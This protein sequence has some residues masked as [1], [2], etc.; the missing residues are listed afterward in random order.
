MHGPE[1]FF[2]DLTALGL[3]YHRQATVNGQVF[4]IFPDYQV[5][6]GRFAGR[7]IELG[8]EAVPS[9]PQAV[10]PSIH[11][12]ATPQL[13]DYSDSAANVRNIIQSPLGAEWR[14]WSLNFS[15]APGRTLGDLFGQISA[16]F[17]HA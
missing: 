8:L 13:F 12:H 4:A 10:A 7:V 2:E 6:G 5:P 15:W 9:Y 16:V 1:R 3:S 14:Y 11:V 17:R